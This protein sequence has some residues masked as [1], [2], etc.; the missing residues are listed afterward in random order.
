MNTASLNARSVFMMLKQVSI[1]FQLEAAHSPAL[2]AT[3]SDCRR[4]PNHAF[5]ARP[6]WFLIWYPLVR[7]K[8]RHGHGIQHAP[9]HASEYELSQ[10]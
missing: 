4:Y 8:R 2:G 3:S 9:R 5:G 10:A 6:R 1:A 7:H